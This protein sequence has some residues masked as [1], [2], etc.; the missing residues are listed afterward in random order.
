[1][2]VQG[3]NVVKN[4]HS[5]NVQQL[6]AERSIDQCNESMC[7]GERG[8]Q[9]KSHSWPFGVIIAHGVMRCNKQG[10][11]HMLAFSAHPCYPSR[12]SFVTA[13]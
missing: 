13:T 2:H 4:M 3:E 6:S 5:R 12:P 9:E 11:Q 1:M 10:Y 8:K 7:T